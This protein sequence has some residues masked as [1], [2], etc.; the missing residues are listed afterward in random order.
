MGNVFSVRFHVIYPF[1]LVHRSV[2]ELAAKPNHAAARV[3][4]KGR[5]KPEDKFYEM[6]AIFS[7]L[8]NVFVSLT[9]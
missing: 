1:S 3:L 4:C 9:V 2:L 7:C 5:G 6:I 8:L